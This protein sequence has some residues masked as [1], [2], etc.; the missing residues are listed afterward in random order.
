MENKNYTVEI[1]AEGLDRE[2]ADALFAHLLE[3]A[4]QS[5]KG[6]LITGGVYETPTDAEQIEIIKK[7]IEAITEPMEPNDKK[8]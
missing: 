2:T 5:G 4:D 7:Q 1:H 6:L 8:N 3:I